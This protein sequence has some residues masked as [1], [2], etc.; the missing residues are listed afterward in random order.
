VREH[1]RGREERAL[2][3]SPASGRLV[4]VRVGVRVRVRVRARARARVSACAR[5]TALSARGE[6]VR[7]VSVAKAP[8]GTF[9]EPSPAMLRSVLVLF[10]PGYGVG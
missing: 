3:V 1:Q 10:A 4:R 5:A 7:R 2:P 9:T 8:L 6:T